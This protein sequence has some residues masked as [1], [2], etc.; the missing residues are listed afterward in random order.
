MFLYRVGKN[1]FPGGTATISNREPNEFYTK[2]KRFEN[3]VY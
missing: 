2:L 3:G 1:I